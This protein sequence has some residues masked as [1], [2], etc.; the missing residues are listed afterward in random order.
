MSSTSFHFPWVAW[1][2]D[3]HSFVYCSSWPVLFTFSC[4]KKL[5]LQSLQWSGSVRGKNVPGFINC[6]SIEA[7]GFFLLQLIKYWERFL[8]IFSRFSL[9]DYL[10]FN[11]ALPGWRGGKHL[12]MTLLSTYFKKADTVWSLLRN[13]CTLTVL[14]CVLHFSEPH[15][16]D[17]RDLSLGTLTLQCNGRNQLVCI[18]IE[19]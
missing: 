5:C 7:K 12:K 6:E 8:F 18:W 10:Y 13:P 3:S 4:V 2:S 1:S 9:M 15:L 14:F 19:S 16:E 11:E 17:R